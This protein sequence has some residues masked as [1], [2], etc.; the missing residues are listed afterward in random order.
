MG[1]LA[2]TLEGHRATLLLDPGQQAES[3]SGR[4][5]IHHACSQALTDLPDVS[6][7]PEGMSFFAHLA[8]ARLSLLSGD[9][10]SADAILTG[11]RE[12]SHAEYYWWVDWLLGE[13]ARA[14]GDHAAAIPLLAS[15]RDFLSDH[16][17]PVFEA[18]VGSDL[19]L[20]YAQANRT[21]DA[22]GALV[23]S[24]EMLA[25]GED[26]GGRGGVIV[27]AEALLA[28]E[29]DGPDS[30]QP[31]FDRALD[32]FRRYKVVWH[33][34][35][36]LHLWGLAFLDVR[37]H[38]AALEKL[39]QVLAVYRRIEAG[40]PWFERVLTDKLRAQGIDPADQTTSIDSIAV[41]VTEDRPDLSG[42][43]VP[44]GT[45][46]LLFSDIE[47]STALTER[48]GD[49]RWIE[50]LR[51]HNQ[52][53]RDQLADHQ[54]Y[55]VKSM[56]DGFML[57]FRSAI[58]GLRCAIGMQQAFAEHNA[59]ADEALR[60]RIGLHTGEAIKEADDF[61]GTHVNLAARIGGASHGDEIL[62]SGL[63]KALT[64][65]AREFSFDEG[66]EVEL[67]GISRTQQVHAVEWR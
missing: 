5:N 43:A 18:A 36:A 22:G 54:G 53:V 33:E 52:I 40:T 49:A 57:A 10:E 59:H 45:V 64:E 16:G 35:E 48:L 26:W 8:R 63:L 28:A 6:D 1:P 24:R 12:Q 51:Q 47:G 4:L 31:H 11:W 39:D 41:S 37:D 56:G 34:A 29:K 13:N 67:K 2:Q 62:V 55:E 14:W 65:S 20:A 23:H 32:I 30:A 17:V 66:R 50:L 21:L 60:V 9:R 58:D 46:T 44:D 25:N 42:Q 61:F 7:L 19:A 15:A 3:V 38:A 27:L